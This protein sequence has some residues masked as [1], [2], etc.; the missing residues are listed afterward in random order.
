[1]YLNRPLEFIGPY[2]L[3]QAPG[4]FPLGSDSQALGRF[5]QV[6][7]GERVCD[8]GCGSGVLA[9]Y[10]LAREPSLRLTGIELD[11]ASA[12]LAARNFHANALDAQVIQADLRQVRQLFPNGSFDLAVSNPPYFS[13]GS[14][15]SGGAAR[16]EETCTLQQV[17]AAAGWLV[18]NGGR[19]A[20]VHRPE[21]LCDLF[22]AL[23]DCQ[24]EPKRMQFLQAADKPPSAVLIEAYK[25]GRPGLQVLPPILR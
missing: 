4:V 9:L 21:R 14:G 10:L 18:K 1:M 17:C 20:L 24:L 13:V 7:R 16:M 19:F 23:R 12:A 5:T 25:Q 15:Y 22:A 3:E 8:L 6:R 2:T 11:G